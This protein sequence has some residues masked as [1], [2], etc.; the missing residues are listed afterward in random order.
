MLDRVSRETGL[1][2]H[3]ADT[4]PAVAAH[5]MRQPTRIGL[6]KGANSMPGGWMKW[7]FE[8]YEFNHEV[9]SA[10][11]FEGELA[12]KYDG[13]VR[14]PSVPMPVPVPEKG[15]PTDNRTGGLL[16]DTVRISERDSSRTESKTG[17]GHGE[18]HGSR[19]SPGTSVRNLSP[20]AKMEETQHAVRCRSRIFPTFEQ[21]LAMSA[22]P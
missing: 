19:T 5:Q 9:I 13:L 6:W 4:V 10:H 8:Q 20:F 12:A 7:L 16:V 17:H 21:C 14:L 15:L 2:V 22:L 1:V 3:G 18:E 11:D